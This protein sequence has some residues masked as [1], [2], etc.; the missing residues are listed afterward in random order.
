MIGGYAL[1]A[2]P[3]RWGASGVMSFTCNHDGVVY[4]KDLGP[5]TAEIARAMARFDP[6]TGW[7]AVPEK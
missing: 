3:A 5:R 6:D 1:V 2:Y 7:A 4:Q